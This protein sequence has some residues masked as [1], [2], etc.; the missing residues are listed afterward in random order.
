MTRLTS[1]DDHLPGMRKR[2]SRQYRARYFVLRRQGDSVAAARQT[3]DR[4]GTVVHGPQD[5]SIVARKRRGQVAIQEIRCPLARSLQIPGRVLLVLD[6]LERVL[7]FRLQVVVVEL[8][9]VRHHSPDAEQGS[10]KGLGRRRV[11]SI[12]IARG[13]GTKFRIQLDGDA[14]RTDLW[15]CELVHLA[16]LPVDHHGVL[17]PRG[18]VTQRECAAREG[19]NLACAHQD[20]NFCP[21]HAVIRQVEVVVDA[22]YVCEGRAEGQPLSGGVE[23]HPAITVVFR[24]VVPRSVQVEEEGHGNPVHAPQDAG[25]ALCRLGQAHD[26]IDAEAKKT[27]HDDVHV[28]RDRRRPLAQLVPHLHEEGAEVGGQRSLAVRGPVGLDAVR[29]CRAELETE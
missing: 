19:V 26:G 11:Q 9:N 18:R 15:R 7:V 22:S 4:Q 21:A 28:A 27:R 2:L 29:E 6:Q 3:R 1:F 8:P 12:D 13:V 16:L 20:G 23:R 24:R 10:G 14:V 25:H 5:A 17:L